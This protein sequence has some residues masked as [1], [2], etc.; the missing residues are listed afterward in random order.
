MIKC[1]ECG[2]ENPEGSKYCSECGNEIKTTLN[3]PVKEMSNLWYF[4]TF[5]IPLIG[6]LGGMYYWGKGYKNAPMVLY[7]GLFMAVINLIIAF[8]PYL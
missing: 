3:K 5:F 1:S 7:F 4:V 6:I 8:W 2:F